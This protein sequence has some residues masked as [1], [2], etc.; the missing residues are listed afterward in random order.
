MMR[1]LLFASCL[2]VAGCAAKFRPV[3]ENEA[4]E[5]PC[6]KRAVPNLRNELYH[7]SV[8]VYG[9]H[10]SGLM[11]FKT[12]PDS[13]T[14]VVFTT[15][16]G[17]TFFN[18]SW[19]KA[20]EFNVQHIIKNLDKKAVI[21][22]LR[23]DLEL[24]IVPAFYVNHAVPAGEHTQAVRLNKETIFFAMSEDCSSIEKVEVKHKEKL[25]TKVLFF[26]IN[27]NVPDSVN[28]E[29]LNFNMKLALGRINR[30]HA[31]E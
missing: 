25:K 21:N 13:S 4:F 30:D 1:Y 17:L 15:E 20:G 10:I 29:H 26:P 5:N 16:T 11:F 19:D 3:S 12:L 27:K 14:R 31:A 6:L 18:F 9:H 2:L 7:A 24:M 28:I 8:D 22:L 23:K